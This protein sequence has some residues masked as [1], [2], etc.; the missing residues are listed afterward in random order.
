MVTLSEGPFYFSLTHRHV[1]VAVSNVEKFPTQ[2]RYPPSDAPSTRILTI[3][4]RLVTPK[5]SLDASREPELPAQNP[6]PLPDFYC[7][8][9]RLQNSKTKGEENQKESVSDYSFS[10]PLPVVERAKP[11]RSTDL[12]NDLALGRAARSGGGSSQP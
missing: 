4:L 5:P 6:V 8:L 10:S 3:H 9:V 1:S 7:S 11:L 12:D 2:P